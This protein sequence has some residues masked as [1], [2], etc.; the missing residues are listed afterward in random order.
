[1][2]TLCDTKYIKILIDLKSWGIGVDWRHNNITRPYYIDMLCL[3][4]ELG[5]DPYGGNDEEE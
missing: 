5:I 1:M 2:W 4:I 3:C